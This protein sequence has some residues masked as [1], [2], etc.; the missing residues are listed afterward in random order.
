MRSFLGWAVVAAVFSLAGSASAQVIGACLTPS[1][2]LKDVTVG[3]IPSCGGNESAISWNV[4]GQQG[5]QG[6]MGGTGADGA[7]G[8][9]VPQEVILG[10]S[11]IQRNGFSVD[12]HAADDCRTTYGQGARWAETKDLKTLARDPNAPNELGWVNISVV[13]VR[14]DNFIVDSSGFVGPVTHLACGTIDSRG[15]SLPWVGIG[16]ISGFAATPVASS[17]VFLNCTVES[18]AICVGPKPN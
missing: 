7:P 5:P 6:D 3:S 8:T 4:E 18:P 11:Q 14:A 2:D 9:S 13:T 15:F 1:G 16:G 17:P 10:S 12:G